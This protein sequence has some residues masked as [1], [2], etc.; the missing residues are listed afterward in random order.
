[1]A[2]VISFSLFGFDSER[3]EGCFDF[4]SYFRYL[5]LNLRMAALIYPDWIVNIVLDEPTYNSVYKYFFDYHKDNGKLTF[6]VVPS[7]PLCKMMLQ[8]MSPAFIE[9]CDRFICRDLDSLFS[10][11][12]AQAVQF[13]VN[14]GRVCSAITDSISH[15]ISLMGGM[16]GFQSKEFSERMKVDSFEGLLSYDTNINFS[17]KGSD[18]TFLNQR[19]LP[20]VADSMVEHYV[21]GMKNS[22]RDMCYDHI[23]DIELSIPIELKES[24][25]LINHIGQ[26]GYAIEPALLFFDKHMTE[27]QK[28]Y[29]DKIEKEYKQIFYWHN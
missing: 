3:A 4:N 25:Q 19:V 11:R 1:M 2:N 12:E 27:T 20:R 17:F 5:S 8:R 7:Q 15:T 13:W 29:Y 6:Q 24:N 16:I 21:L 18:Q 23:Q 9:G 28:R 26:S 22:F 10:Y 14:A